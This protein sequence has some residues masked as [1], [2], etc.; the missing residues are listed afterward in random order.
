MNKRKGTRYYIVL[1]FIGEPSDGITNS[2]D[3]E[4]FFSRDSAKKVWEKKYKAS[5]LP[6]YCL[7]E[8][9]ISELV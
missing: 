8:T 5:G 9:T 3:T 2:Y 6:F 4:V 7:K 1:S